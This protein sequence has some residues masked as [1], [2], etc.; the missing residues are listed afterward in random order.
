MTHLDYFYQTPEDKQNGRKPIAIP[1]PFYTSTPTIHQRFLELAAHD[2]SK[3]TKQTRS[4][5]DYPFISGPYVSAIACIAPSESI[6]QLFES[7]LILICFHFF[8][9]SIIF[10]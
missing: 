1:V 5:K 2:P 8:S 7:Y 4:I 10:T 6:F 9:F 3:T